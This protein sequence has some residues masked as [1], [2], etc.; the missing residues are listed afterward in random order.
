MTTRQRGGK[1]RPFLRLSHC[2]QAKT[3]R[4]KPLFAVGRITPHGHLMSGCNGFKMASFE[5][6]S[7][8]LWDKKDWKFNI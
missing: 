6:I 2:F 3:S 8:S 4:F 5:Y 1:Y 7:I